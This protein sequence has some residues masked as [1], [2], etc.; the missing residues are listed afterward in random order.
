MLVPAAPTVRDEM[1]VACGADAIDDGRVDS[2]G[3]ARLA[4]L[5]AP[6]H[7]LQTR[8]RARLLRLA[9][10]ANPLCLAVLVGEG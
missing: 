8:W 9:F 6:L 5:V 3:R 2:A 1:Y 7:S 4:A 10:A